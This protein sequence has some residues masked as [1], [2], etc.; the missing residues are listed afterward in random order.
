MCFFFFFFFYTISLCKMSKKKKKGVK[1]ETDE[2][3]K[4]CAVMLK[5]SR[6]SR[7]DLRAL[8]V[9]KVQV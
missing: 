2:N 7:R 1:L 6:V 5:R 9:Y 3:R 8:Q 4:V